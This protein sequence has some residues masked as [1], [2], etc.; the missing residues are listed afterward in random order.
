MDPSR[1]Q[2]IKAQLGASDSPSVAT[3]CRL[4]TDVASLVAQRLC[5][6]L[7]CDHTST[8]ARM[9]HN[10]NGDLG[11]GSAAAALFEVWWSRHFRPSLVRLLSQDPAVRLMVGSGDTAGILNLLRKLDGRLGRQPEQ[12]L[13]TLL[14]AT[15]AGAFD[16]CVALMGEEPEL[17][18]W[19]RIHSAHSRILSARSLR[20]K[21]CSGTWVPSPKAATA[22]RL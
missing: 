17:W 2:R 4:Q 12:V 18:A 3:S 6:L 8:A 19:R 9:L 22:L 21:R 5:G 14:A 15:L 11:E 13:D 1:A 20:L 16:D 10:W 7:K